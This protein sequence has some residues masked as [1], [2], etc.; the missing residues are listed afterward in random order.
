MTIH[1]FGAKGCIACGLL[2]PSSSRLSSPQDMPPGDKVTT[3]LE[4]VDCEAC[5]KTYI[6]TTSPTTPK[7]T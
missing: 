2:F 3:R 7:S 4:Y 6:Y 1:A 5:K